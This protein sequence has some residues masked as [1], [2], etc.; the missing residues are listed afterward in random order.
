MRVNKSGY[1]LAEM[2]VT[3]GIIG[4]VAAMV[5]PGLI[6]GSKK[7]TDI[8]AVARGV[9]LVQNGMKNILTTAQNNNK[10]GDGITTLSVIQLKDILGDDI[11]NADTYITD[12]D[13]LFSVTKSFMGTED[14]DN[15]YLA[16]VTDYS[17]ETSANDIYDSF[18]NF[19]AYKFAKNNIVVIFEPIGDNT[20]N[21]NTADDDVIA[22][23]FIDANGAEKPNQFGQDI[24]LFGLTNNG[25]LV[26]A[27]SQA[28]NKNIF[29]EE[30]DLYTDACDE[31]IG[32]GLS[33]AARI[34]ADGW[35]KKY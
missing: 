23:V 28:Y 7:V 4:I 19:P 33:C 3:I 2:L 16:E 21:E 34:M 5:L 6:V 10:D 8:S 24:F 27:G 1:T 29:D 13:L 22:R 30:L 17:E 25:T 15:D 35:S 26:P 32:N 31:N 12:G 14:Y 11:E 9:E 20:I 18:N